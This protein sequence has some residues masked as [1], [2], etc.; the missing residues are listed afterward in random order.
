MIKKYEL[1]LMMAAVC[2]LIATIIIAPRLNDQT[3]E[4][5]MKC[6]ADN[7]WVYV[8]PTCGYCTEQ[9]EILGSYIELFTLIDCSVNQTMCK[10]AEVFGYPTWVIN[11]QVYYGVQ[12]IID[13]KIKSGCA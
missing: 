8:S 4:D 12:D 11:K 2:V 9:K 5:I 3:E 1:I 10:N 6:I 7:S 13:L